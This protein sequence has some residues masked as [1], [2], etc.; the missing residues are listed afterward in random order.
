[1]NVR[2]RSHSL[3]IN[4]RTSHQIR[5]AADRLLPD[6]ITDVDGNQ[7]DC[8]H[9]VSVFNGSTPEVERFDNTDEEIT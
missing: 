4:Y 8:R 9:T 7:E 2:G 3:K 6:T 5:T 1:V